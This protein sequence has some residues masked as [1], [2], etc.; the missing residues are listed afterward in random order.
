M[1]QAGVWLSAAHVAAPIRKL[2]YEYAALSCDDG[3]K[4]L[5]RSEKCLAC[6]V[7]T[8]GEPKSG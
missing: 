6:Q 8:N 7:R 5:T 3:N 2:C 4:D 1:S